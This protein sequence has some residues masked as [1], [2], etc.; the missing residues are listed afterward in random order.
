MKCLHCGV[1]IP[2]NNHGNE[3]TG[4]VCSICWKIY[5]DIKWYKENNM[6]EIAKNIEL[7]FKSRSITP[8]IE[9]ERK[10]RVVQ[11]YLNLWH[12]KLAQ[13]V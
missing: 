3:I 11:D 4:G 9:I 13:T 12:A 6:E 8:K 1:E 2:N 5:K 10:E 7:V